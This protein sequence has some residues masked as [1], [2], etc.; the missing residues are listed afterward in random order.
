MVTQTFKTGERPMARIIKPGHGLPDG[1]K[2]TK[3][4][5]KTTYMRHTYIVGECA[6]PN[7]EVEILPYTEAGVN[8]RTLTP[9]DTGKRLEPDVWVLP[10]T[11]RPLEHDLDR[12]GRVDYNDDTDTSILNVYVE[13]DDDGE[14]TVHIT[15]MSGEGVRVV[16]DGEIVSHG[17]TP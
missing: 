2:V 10:H 7:E 3:R 9:Y 12:Y 17:G 4:N 8:R 11:R 6:F 14:H 16:V 5:G 15:T 13:R 1:W